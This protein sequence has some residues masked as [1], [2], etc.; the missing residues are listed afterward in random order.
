MATKPK[1]SSKIV[2]LATIA[3][4]PVIAPLVDK[5]RGESRD[6]APPLCLFLRVK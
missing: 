5:N 1:S 4:D 3:P 6:C 2:K